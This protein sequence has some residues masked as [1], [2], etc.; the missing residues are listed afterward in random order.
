MFD[1][2]KGKRL[3]SEDQIEGKTPYIGAIDSNNGVANHIGQQPIHSKGTISL[4]YNGSIGEAFFQP[5]DYWATDDV[6]ALYLKSEYG[7][8]SVFTGL[9]IATILRQEKYRFSYGRKW[10]LSE[11]KNTL[12]SLPVKK[13]GVPDWQWMEN[14]MQS[15]PYSD[16]IVL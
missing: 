7:K 14:Y 10:G 13:D 3:T 2:R 15:L 6:N 11:M 12:I 16:R 4:S 5:E 9:F 8:L 1:V